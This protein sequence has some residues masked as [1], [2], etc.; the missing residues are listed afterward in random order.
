MN[1]PARLDVAWN[2]ASGALDA[3][4]TWA[5]AVVR[6]ECEWDP[7]TGEAS[8]RASLD[9]AGDV[10]AGAPSLAGAAVAFHRQAATRW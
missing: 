6:L 9:C 4:R 2:A 8:C 7:A 10:R 5:S 3:S 1:A